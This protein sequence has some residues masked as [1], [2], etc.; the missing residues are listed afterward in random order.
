MNGLL[1]ILLSFIISI[2]VRKVAM[3]KNECM[4]AK[5]LPQLIMLVGCL[6]GGYVFILE[7]WKL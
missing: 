7:N 2:I 6:Y 5:F 3:M 4:M 1:I